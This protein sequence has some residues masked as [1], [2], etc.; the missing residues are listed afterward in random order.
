MASVSAGRV[1]GVVE[2][3]SWR[4]PAA[5]VCRAWP[6]CVTALAARWCVVG[7]ELC[8]VCPIVV[9]ID[10]PSCSEPLPVISLCLL[11]VR[12]LVDYIV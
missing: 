11:K 5:S 9:D 3:M 4:W 6:A 7:S 8:C 1:L 10:R 12:V 2:F